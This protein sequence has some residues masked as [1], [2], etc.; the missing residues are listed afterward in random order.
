[1]ATLLTIIHV[2][3]C[4]FLILVVLLQAGKGGGVGVALGGQTS[5]QVFGG[6]GAGTFLERL[7]AG[8]AIVFMLTSM[9]LAYIASQSDSARLQKLAVE[10]KTK[11][12]AAAKKA[13]DEK[14][15]KDAEER[16]RKDAAKPEGA[17]VPATPVEES[18]A[19]TPKGEAAPVE[20]KAEEKASPVVEKK[21]VEKKAAPIEKKAAPIEKKAAPVEK[22]AEEP[23]PTQ[24]E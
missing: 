12:D 17:A 22:K 1:M 7:T 2:I 11:A 9:S 20:K 3:A 13:A 4:V 15:A 19:P 16:A 23:A 24:P 18:A 14:A 6:R 21:A 8:T 10:Q 5:A